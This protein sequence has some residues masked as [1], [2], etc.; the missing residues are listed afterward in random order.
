MI[1]GYFNLLHI[2]IISHTYSAHPFLHATS[3]IHNISLLRQISNSRLLDDQS[4][5][6][7]IL[8]PHL[9]IQIRS[10]NSIDL[11]DSIQLLDVVLT[12]K[13]CK[14]DNFVLKFNIYINESLIPQY[15]VSYQAEWSKS[16]LQC[17]R[18]IPQDFESSR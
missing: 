1:I 14:F 8:P 4:N 12:Y 18:V 6:L 5:A 15:C 10:R 11:Q 13:N 7:S 2:V 3:F 16:R 9:Y 17:L